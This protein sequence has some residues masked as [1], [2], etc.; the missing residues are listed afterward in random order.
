MSSPQPLNSD[1]SQTLQLHKSRRSGKT[2]L[3]LLLI[4]ALLAGGYYAWLASHPI[5]ETPRYVTQA[6][7]Q[8]DLLVKVSATGNLEPINQVDVG[9]ELSGMIEA[10][11]V[12]DN[13]HVI[14][15]QVLA[16]LDANRLRDQANKSRAALTASEAQVVQAA[17]TVKE[18]RSQLNRLHE[19]SKRSNG[20][21]V[22]AYDLSTAEAV[23]ARAVASEGVARA[24]VEQARAALNSDET[25]LNKS[26][27]RSPI[28]GI[29][30]ARKVEPGQTVAASFQAPVLFTL[31]E[32]L[33]RMELHV[34]VDEADVGQVQPGQAARF[35]VDAWRNRRYPATV[36]RVNYGS[37]VKDNVVTYPTM[38]EVN[39]QD[40]SLRPG[41][42]ATA[43]IT[44]LQRANALLVPNAALRFN[45][46]ATPPKAASTSLVSSLVPKPP[47]S[48]SQRGNGKKT[49][50]DGKQTLYVL[51]DGQAVP[52]EVKIG[53]S[54]G[55]QTEILEGD[56]QPGTP[57]IIERSNGKP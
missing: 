20:Q 10:V 30:L 16:R 12:D 26:V 46:S 57:I 4:L 33:T 56:I 28:N 50:A 49:E 17:A 39:N 14:Q 36:T 41:M 51:R 54:D 1:P 47:R 38:L 40:L 37:E 24:G 43:E 45:P 18:T 55:K 48:A 21:L 44:T 23:H 53:L 3:I 9:S 2:W 22:S 25:N 31:A 29:V 6:A 8:G 5:Q 27:I 52:V 7:E 15:G 32:D 11:L 34:A 35:T 19:L 13:D 42:T